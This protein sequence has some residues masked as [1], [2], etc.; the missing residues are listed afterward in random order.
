MRRH[1]MPDVKEGNVNVTPLIDIVMCLIIFFMLVA[2]IGVDTGADQAIVIPTSFRGLEIQDMGNT[3]TLNV[4]PIAGSDQPMVSALVGGVVEE[5][6]L[7]DPVTGHK[8]LLAT[9]KNFRFGKDL[10][11]GGVAESADNPEFKVIIRGE[12]SMGYQFLEPVL[13]TCAEARVKNVNFNTK[14]AAQ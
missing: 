9:L 12:E 1:R 11:P 2:K 5:L 13:I 10:R 3:L 14:R 8:P 7:I 4:R 6:K